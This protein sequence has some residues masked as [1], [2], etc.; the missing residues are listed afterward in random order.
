[1]LNEVI[2]KNDYPVFETKIS[3]FKH[4]PLGIGV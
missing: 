1:M 3:N 4:R 2:D